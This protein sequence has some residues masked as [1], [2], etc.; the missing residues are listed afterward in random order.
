[1]SQLQNG[2]ADDGGSVSS[3]LMPQF[4]TALQITNPGS[5]YTPFSTVDIRYSANTGTLDENFRLLNRRQVFS[6]VAR[7]HIDEDGKVAGI[8]YIHPRAPM[9]G[10]VAAYT[11]RP[12]FTLAS[13]NATVQGVLGHPLECYYAPQAIFDGQIEADAD[14]SLTIAGVG[15]EGNGSLILAYAGGG[16]SFPFVIRAHDPS[17]FPSNSLIVATGSSFIAK[18]ADL[19]IGVVGGAAGL[20]RL[21]S[22]TSTN[23][24]LR[25]PSEDLS[26]RKEIVG[27]FSTAPD[28]VLEDEKG[29]GVEFTTASLPA[30]GAVTGE[31]I[32]ACSVSDGGT[33]YTLGARLRLVGG[34]PLAWDNPATAT[35]S[36]ATN[37]RILSLSL[38]QG[39][40]G[41]TTP[42]AVYVVGDGEGA[43]ATVGK[44]NPDTGAIESLRLISPGTGYTQATVVFVDRET[45]AERNPGVARLCDLFDRRY[46]VVLKKCKVDRAT[47][48]PESR[49][50]LPTLAT[51]EFLSRGQREPNWNE[52]A[53]PT[54]TYSATGSIEFQASFGGATQL[55]VS[56]TGLGTQDMEAA[57]YRFHP[58]Y[59]SDGLVEYV[60]V[61]QHYGEIPPAPVT[62]TI[63]PTSDVQPSRDAT[64]VAAIP[65]CGAVF[66]G[67]AASPA[68]DFDFP[69]YQLT[70]PG[71]DDADADLVFNVACSETYSN[72]IAGNVDVIKKGVGD[73]ALTGQVDF[74]GTLYVQSGKVFM[75]QPPGGADMVISPAA[76]VVISGGGSHG[77][78]ITGSGTLV[79]RGSGTLTLSDTSGFNG[80]ILL[81]EGTLAGAVSLASELIVSGGASLSAD[82]T[83]DG[84]TI[85]L[86]ASDGDIQLSGSIAGSGTVIKRGSGRLIF[87]G[88]A[89]FLGQF[90]F[91][92]GSGS[93][94]GSGSVSS[95]V[96]LVGVVVLQ[97]GTLSGDASVKDALVVSDGGS[98]L[99]N[100]HLPYESSGLIFNHDGDIQYS[101]SVTGNGNV[102]KRGNGKLTF[103]G[104]VFINGVFDVEHGIL[105]G[106]VKLGGNTSLVIDSVDA[107]LAASIELNGGVIFWTL[108][109]DYAYSGV[110]SGHGDV[111][112]SGPGTLTL[113]A[114]ST[115]AGGFR[116]A[117]V[118]VIASGGGLDA[119]ITLASVTAISDLVFASGGEY[120]GVIKGNGTVIK[121]G[122]G[123]LTLTKAATFA[124]VID[125]QEGSLVVRELIAD[126]FPLVSA[127]YTP[128]SL[129]FEFS[130]DPSGDY[131]IFN[132][133]TNQMYPAVTLVGTTKTGY[134][135]SDRSTLTIN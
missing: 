15:V 17:L 128:E 45:T 47:I 83:L 28:L 36:I 86:D 101:G 38:Q 72:D 59:E 123:G 127:T 20:I 91:E 55:F 53:L 18:R 27:F 21:G 4:V 1:M 16:P 92:N 67:S 39:G 43:S 98:L 71:P 81:E 115:Y 82:V 122:A 113:L 44:I 75:N 63:E 112:K 126:Q 73:L 46:G 94:G 48:P 85:I 2:D 66:S 131:I 111:E 10:G 121:S 133:R 84:G 25:W 104:E 7:A 129:T 117:G 35:A 68:E 69:P 102:R 134:Y 54:V 5:G 31:W 8:S 125:V 135:D 76:S 107:E 88:E 62:V 87:N 19:R 50:K 11:S 118:L 119:D 64:A 23:D 32:E 108:Y 90:I 49:K 61:E 30:S 132:A 70:D 26:L 34:R 103:N 6:T 33:G 22:L 78:G 110:I 77:G 79:K 3:V 41:Y 96:E 105:D 40:K 65:R 51:G 42:P 80:Q 99:A 29:S 97:E 114:K 95:G 120:T 100:V 14:V 74:A 56:L 109:S 37:G 24:L 89:A 13:G 60:R 116:V 12:N 124:G 130:G 58:A 93:L 57:G 52:D 9:L 106:D